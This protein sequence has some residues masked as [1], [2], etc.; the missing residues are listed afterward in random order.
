MAESKSKKAVAPGGK[1]LSEAVSVVL[2]EYNGP[3]NVTYVTQQIKKEHPTWKL[4]ERRVNKFVKRYMSEDK[5]L[6][7]AD[8]D[9]TA[10]TEYN[11]TEKTPSSPSKLSSSARSI[12]NL[13]S[14]KSSKKKG[15]SSRK[16]D[17]DTTSEVPSSPG[18][19][20]A[21]EPAAAAAVSEE[22]ELPVEE[23]KE[24]L[25]S[26][27]PIVAVEKEEPEK[28]IAYETDNEKVDSSNDCFA[29]CSIM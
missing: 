28:E 23:T 5:N 7:G 3:V 24:E 14:S 29:L 22:K 18:V 15:L 16:F 20:T 1:D 8:D 6:A 13:F 17:M 26:E 21:P 4:P 25:P 12:R 19:E 27:E 9:A 10:A 11:K 2:K